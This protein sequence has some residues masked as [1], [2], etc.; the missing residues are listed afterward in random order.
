MHHMLNNYISYFS[1][2]HKKTN[3]KL[4]INWVEKLAFFTQSSSA[5]CH[6]EVMSQV[7][8]PQPSCW[9]MCVDWFTLPKSCFEVTI[10]DVETRP[11]SAD[12]R[13]LTVST[14]PGGRRVSVTSLCSQLGHC[15]RKPFT[16]P[17]PSFLPCT[18]ISPPGCSD[19]SFLPLAGWRRGPVAVE[20]GCHD[21]GAQLYPFTLGEIVSR[22]SPAGPHHADEGQHLCPWKLGVPAGN[23]HLLQLLST[24]CNHMLP[25]NCPISG[26]TLHN[27]YSPDAPFVI[28]N[29]QVH[30]NI[31]K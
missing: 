28:I 17:L 30:C 1:V 29:A 9:L 13:S 16:P 11:H 21:N 10:T 4:V 14:G 23:A 22:P 3:V 8:T 19:P 15:L 24:R 31:I 18:V 25:L 20:N 26:A 27:N 5:Y 6:E 7:K 12:H 2:L